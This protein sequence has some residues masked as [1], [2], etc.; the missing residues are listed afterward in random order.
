MTSKPEHNNSE[1]RRSWSLLG[2]NL[3]TVPDTAIRYTAAFS[4]L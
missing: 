2:G 1:L 3:D 4:V